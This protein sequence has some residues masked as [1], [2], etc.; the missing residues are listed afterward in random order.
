METVTREQADIQLANSTKKIRW[1][2]QWTKGWKVELQQSNR[3][4]ADTG[5]DS[6]HQG[7]VDAEI[8]ALGQPVD[9]PT[10][11]VTQKCVSHISQEVRGKL[12]I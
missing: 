7:E 4:G 5:L 3:G 10:E 8:W 1:M 11:L 6:L 9:C 2:V 12:S